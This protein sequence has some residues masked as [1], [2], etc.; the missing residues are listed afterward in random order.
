MLY[1]YT[2]H[3]YIMFGIYGIVP[4]TITPLHLT[5]LRHQGLPPSLRW[6]G[7]LPFAVAVH[8]LLQ[9]CASRF[10][11]VQQFST[12][13]IESMGSTIG[14]CHQ[15][16]IL[17]DF[18]GYNREYIINNDLAEQAEDLIWGGSFFVMEDPKSPWWR[19]NTSHESWSND[20]D[21]RMGYP[22]DLEVSIKQP[23]TPI[24]K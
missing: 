8:V 7:H 3:I 10:E 2:V 1:V 15:W 12:M 14:I 22:Q 18:M 11:G 9:R 21:E 17:W 13:G 16:D 4:K 6:G 24:E 5:A 20:L 23:A 19:F